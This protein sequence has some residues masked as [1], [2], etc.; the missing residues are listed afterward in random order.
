MSL[1]VYRE[2]LTSMRCWVDGL[3]THGFHRKQ[4]QCPACRRKWSFRN[5][6]IRLELLFAYAEE[7][8][9]FDA[10]EEVGCSRNTA[11]AFFGEMLG[12]SSEIVRLLLRVGGISMVGDARLE[13]ELL[14]IERKPGRFGK[15]LAMSRAVFFHGLSLEQRIRL[16]AEPEILA[17]AELAWKGERGKSFPEQIRGVGSG[18]PRLN[19]RDRLLLRRLREEQRRRVD[20]RAMATILPSLNPA[21]FLSG[22][23]Q[24]VMTEKERS[25]YEAFHALQRRRIM[26]AS[27]KQDIPGETPVRPAFYANEHS[28]PHF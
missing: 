15:K 11:Q 23:N 21:L 18:Y 22:R 27:E 25:F 3:K 2:Y 12:R 14:R 28:V 6:L 20:L 17:A 24:T 16:L 10:A 13:R 19:W 26:E 7:K 8:T 1:E 9:A 4:R 5:R